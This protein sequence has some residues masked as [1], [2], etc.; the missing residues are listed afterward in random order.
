MTQKIGIVVKFVISISL[1]S[2]LLWLM[3]GKYSIIIN[4]LK[5][6]NLILFFSAFLLFCVNI[7]FITLRFDALLLGENIRMPF[8]KLIELNF[9]GYFFNN[10]MPSAV[11][12]DII[13]A[14]YTGQS[15][16]KKAKSY[17]SVFMDRFTGL[18]SFALIALVATF[19]SWQTIADNTI[20]I[21]VLTFAGIVLLLV[22]VSL[23]VKIANFLTGFLK[24]VKVMN[25]GK[26]LAE[27]YSI[28]HNY[29]NKKALLIKAMI[30]S[31]IGQIFYF[32]VVYLLFRSVG[33]TVP[34]SLIFLVMPI[35][36][37]VSMLPSVG[38]L[39]IR[40]G[41]IVCFFAPMVGTERA[42]GVSIL[43]LVNLFLIS[44]IGGIIYLSSRQFRNVKI[45]ENKNFTG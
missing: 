21:S 18:L 9:I 38:G 15:T 44:I 33:L 40:E 32:T 23:N 28:M 7:V 22:V 2:L 39:G 16:G 11:G 12:G 43:L 37:V 29:R 24:K 13:K 30:I 17:V 5:N 45:A 26:K 8:I 1:I 4:E 3:R 42:F 34:F 6:T 14:Y 36:S 10:F 35:V 41:A 19:L 27:L 20:K 31:I 25:L